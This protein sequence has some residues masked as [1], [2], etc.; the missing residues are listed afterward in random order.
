MLLLNRLLMMCVCVC[1]S[2]VC[3]LHVRVSSG[4]ENID[5]SKHLSWPEIQ[6]DDPDGQLKQQVTRLQVPSNNFLKKKRNTHSCKH[7]GCQLLNT[8]QVD[9]GRRSLGRSGAK[10][11]VFASWPLLRQGKGRRTRG[12]NSWACCFKS[13]LA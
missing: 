2:Y 13:G 10:A 3:L 12:G 1:M 7:F 4:Y 6:Q 11:N 9:Q 5:V 8:H